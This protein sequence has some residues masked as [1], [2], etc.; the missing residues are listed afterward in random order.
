MRRAHLHLNRLACAG[1]VAICVAAWAMLGILPT[2]H[3][4]ASGRSTPPDRK[5][6]GPESFAKTPKT[7]LE[8][9]DAVDYLVRV[10]HADQAVPYLKAFVDSK[11][12]DTMLLE[13]RD[14]YGDGSIMRLNDD[15]ATRPQARPLMEMLAAAAH[16]QATRPERIQRSIASL[17]RSPEEQQ[18]GVEQLRRAG[19]YAVPYLI[20]A[21][22]RE[23]LSRGERA[24]IVGNMGRLDRSA[25]PALISVLDS[26]DATLAADAAEALGRIGDPRAIPYLTFFAA[27]KDTLA[28]LRTASRRALEQLT[29]RPFESQAKSAVRVLTDEARKYQTHAVNFPGDQVEL[30]V[31]DQGPTPK[32][33]SRS[34]AEGIL[35]LR[36]AR[37]ALTLD[38]ADPAAQVAFVSLALE[39]AVE[40]VGLNAFPGSDPDGVFASV[41][42]TGPGILNEVLH[43]ALATGHSELAAAAVTALGRVADRNALSSLHRPAPLVEALT[44]PDRRVQFAAA[45]ALIELEPQKAFPGSSRVVPVLARFVTARAEPRAVIID[46]NPNQGSQLVAFLKSLGYDPILALTGAQGFRLAAGSAD[47]ELIILDPALV[48]SSWRAIDTLSNLRADANTAGIPIFL[49]GPLKLHQRLSDMAAGLPRVGLLVTPVNAEILKKQLDLELGRMGARPLSSAE[50]DRYAQQASFL[51]ARVAAR[52]SGPFESD[53][54]A[55]GPALVVALRSPGTSQAAAIAL[56]NVP[57]VD[58]QRG[59]ADLLLDPAKPAA[60]RLSAAGQL[61]RSI[62]RFGRLVSA[63]QEQ[64]LVDVLGQTNDPALRTALAA[65]I[66]ALRPKPSSVGERLQALSPAPAESAPPAPAPGATPAPA[67]DSTAPPPAPAPDASPAPAPEGTV[68]PPTEPKN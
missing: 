33:V 59:L 42:A 68:P 19:P 21:L 24:V 28:P 48:E 51:L 60:L 35:G 30:W 10:G 66:G 29:G 32:V 9:W 14:R 40:H 5:A 23:G 55:A 3:G 6:P 27:Q 45:R 50:R 17:T 67:Q 20:Q 36:F 8:L 43:Q 62:Q 39:K 56:A 46:S 13:I 38:P 41:L 7:P 34:E 65:V 31:W 2:A 16:R 22:S 15:P 44:A 61:S 49:M 11:P 47:V 54:A 52:P 63:T 12:D 25:V 64:R 37:E 26:S 1:L 4:Q 58:A 57:G 18:Y 53:L